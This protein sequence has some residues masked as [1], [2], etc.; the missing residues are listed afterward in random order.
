MLLIF[1]VFTSFRILEYKLISYIV[2]CKLLLET[3]DSLKRKGYFFHLLH[4]YH[5]SPHKLHNIGINL[6][7]AQADQGSAL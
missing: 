5:R 7:R 6:T 4:I 1:Y 3:V 2:I